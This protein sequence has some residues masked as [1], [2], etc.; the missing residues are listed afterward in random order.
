MV[1]TNSENLCL[2]IV[3]F[4]SSF[5]EITSHKWV[6]YHLTPQ[7]LFR[8]VQWKTPSLFSE[9]ST[10]LH[11]RELQGSSGLT[12][13]ESLYF[14]ESPFFSSPLCCFRFTSPR[15]TLILDSS[16]ILSGGYDFLWFVKFMLQPSISKI[17]H[18][19]RRKMLPAKTFSVFP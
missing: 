2:N 12:G 13:M 9:A 14:F 19:F 5:S 16:L 7:T 10:C 18:S 4:T 15:V 1:P 11:K 6:S 3:I 17:L 8:M